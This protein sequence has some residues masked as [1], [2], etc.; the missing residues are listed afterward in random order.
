MPTARRTTQTGIEVHRYGAHLFHTSNERVWEYVNRFTTFTEL[1]AQGLRRAQGR[2]LL[3]AHQPGHDQPVLPGQPHS[4]PGAG[5]DR[6]AGRRTG[7]HR[8]AEPERQGHPAHRPAALRGVHQALHRQAVADGSQ[9][10]ARGHHLPPSRSATTTTTGT[11]TTRTRA[12][13]PTATRP[14]STRWPTTRTSRSGSTPTS[15]TSRTSTA[16]AR[17]SAPSRSSTPAPST[18]TSTTPRATCPGAPIDFEEEVLDVD[19]FQGT[20]VVNYNDDDVPFTRIIEFTPLPPGARLP[21]GKDRHHAR[22]LP[23]RRRR[24]TSP[25]TRST[26]PRTAN[27]AQVP[28]PRGSREAMSSSADASAPTSTWTCTWPSALP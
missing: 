12:C 14:G 7:R 4:R 5:A 15:S 27:A 2:G 8:S 25:T 23:R 28:R 19:D 18:A 26:P 16:R 11:S 21:A 13:R 3:P 17:S 1:R 10:P 9:G 6:G 24:A 22:V 20:S